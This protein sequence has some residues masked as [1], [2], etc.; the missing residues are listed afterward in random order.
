MTLKC[1]ALGVP[2]YRCQ[3]VHCVCVTFQKRDLTREK[4]QWRCQV[5]ELPPSN[6][7][8]SNCDNLNDKF[9]GSGLVFVQC[10]YFVVSNESLFLC[11]NNADRQQN[12]ASLLS[13]NEVNEFEISNHIEQNPCT[14]HIGTKYIRILSANRLW[15]FFLRYTLRRPTNIHIICS[16]QN[17]AKHNTNSKWW[18]QTTCS[19]SHHLPHHTAS[20][21]P[22]SHHNGSRACRH[23]C[24]EAYHK[25]PTAA[26]REPCRTQSG[27]SGWEKKTRTSVNV[28]WM[29]TTIRRKAFEK[30]IKS[31][32][33]LS[34]GFVEV[35]W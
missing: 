27:L 6:A 8:S 25:G 20:T 1:A 5:F 32:W 17:T 7:G 14:P 9:S 18:V 13:V 24:F 12:Y 3:C 4:D 35:Q 11:W 26:Q 23:W 2:S 10:I 29:M 33:I 22:H 28:E 30:N 19:L 15:P 31:I 16:L 34:A 21:A